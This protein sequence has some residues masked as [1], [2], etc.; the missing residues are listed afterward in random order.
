LFGGIFSDIFIVWIVASTKITFFGLIDS[1]LV[2][3]SH[4]ICFQDLALESHLICFQDLALEI[5]LT[6]FQ[7]QHDRSLLLTINVIYKIS[8]NKQ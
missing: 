6:C 3:E 8:S 1:Y 2:F 4:L 7:D 5:H